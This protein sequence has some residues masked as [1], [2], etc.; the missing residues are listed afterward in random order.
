MRVYVPGMSLD[1]VI[2]SSMCLVGA[3]RSMCDVRYPL[4][5]FQIRELWIR[6]YVVMLRSYV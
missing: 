2:C 5:N 3:Y 4:G 6:L 1:G